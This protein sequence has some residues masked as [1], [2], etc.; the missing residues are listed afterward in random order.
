MLDGSTRLDS[1]VPP[2]STGR[3][4]TLMS[5]AWERHPQGLL[6]AHLTWSRASSGDST[7]QTIRLAPHAR[8][9]FG[10]WVFSRKRFSPQAY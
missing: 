10:C 3:G 4:V 8:L 2:S 6:L 5:K 1:T 9:I 7:Y